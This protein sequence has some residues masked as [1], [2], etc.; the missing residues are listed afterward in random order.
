MQLQKEIAAQ[1]G[2]VMEGR[3]I[4]TH[5]LPDA[6]IKFFLTASGAERARRRY[7]EMKRLGFT[8]SYDEVL[9]DIKRRDEIDRNRAVAPLKPAPGA[10][11]IDCSAMSVEQVVDL[12]ISRVSGRSS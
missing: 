7:L 3:D 9:R 8:I 10:F 6:E 1:G 2:V 4:G 11:I 5:V 12:I